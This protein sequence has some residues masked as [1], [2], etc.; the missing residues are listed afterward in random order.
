[1]GTN[2]SLRFTQFTLETWFKWTGGGDPADTGNLGIDDVI[3]LI[4]KGTAEDETEPANINY[5][6][7]I[8]DSSNTLAA[9]F[10]ERIDGAGA[11]GLNHPI[12]SSTVVSTGVWHTTERGTCTWTA[13]TS[14]P[15]RTRPSTSRRTT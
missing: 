3:P 1:V 2:A 11:T 15:R 8:D 7:G 6:F 10:E 12:T 13:S 14:R 9:D 4:A 5:F